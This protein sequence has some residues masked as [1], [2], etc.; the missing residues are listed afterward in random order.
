MF[1]VDYDGER[2]VYL[3]RLEAGEREML[4]ALVDAMRDGEV[5]RWSPVYEWEICDT[6]RGEGGHSRR[7]GVITSEDWDDWSDEDRAHY[8]SGGYDATCDRCG[9]SGKVRVLDMESAPADVQ[10]WVEGYERDLYESESIR[11]AERLAGC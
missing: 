1:R 11:Y 4:L 5:T 7:L 2:D 3:S 6:C 8:L 9:G 10:A